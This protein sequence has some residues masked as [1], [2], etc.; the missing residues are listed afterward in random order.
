MVKVLWLSRHQMSAEQHS[1][2]FGSLLAFFGEDTMITG[3]EVDH[4]NATFPAR[5]RDAVNHIKTLAGDH[6]GVIA[7]V[8]PAH[9]G[10]ALARSIDSLSCALIAV[11]VAVSASASEGETRGGGF[12]HS[13]WE[14]FA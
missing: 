6:Y 10:M 7:G 1:S 13:H 14:L 8:F 9:V 4:F 5:R 11:P 2:L 3:M 12:V